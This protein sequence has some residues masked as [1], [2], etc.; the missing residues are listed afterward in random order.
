MYVH[1]LTQVFFEPKV[2]WE[3]LTADL[4]LSPV[5]SAAKGMIDARG[6]SLRFPRFLRIRDDKTPEES[7]S[8]EQIAQMYR[9][10]AVASKKQRG[11]DDEDDFW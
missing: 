9:A 8:P 4:S 2:V 10:Q 6:V 11:R 7:T 5:Y 3:V 1:E